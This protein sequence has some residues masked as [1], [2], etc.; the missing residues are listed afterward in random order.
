MWGWLV[1]S[2]RLEILYHSIHYID[3]MRSLFGDPVWITSR[4]ARYPLQGNMEGETKTITVLIK[5]DTKPEANETFFLNLSRATNA[6]IADAQG[7]GTILNDD[8]GSVGGG[9]NANVPCDPLPP[10]PDEGY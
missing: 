10:P 4:H 2:P 7:V 8:D 9:C 6:A 5:G 1:V 3:A